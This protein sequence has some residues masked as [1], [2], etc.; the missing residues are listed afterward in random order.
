MIKRTFADVKAELARVAGATGMQVNDGRLRELASIAQERLCLAGE[1]PYQ[2]ARVKFRQYGGVVSLPCEYESLVHTAVEREAVAI[3]PAWF[4]FLEYGPGPVDPARWT[5]LGLDLGE[6]PV[7]QQPGPE[8][9]TLKVTS[10]E[11]AD[12]GSVVVTG[13]DPEGVRRV[14]SFALPQATSPVAWAKISQVTKPATAGDVV[15]S[16]TDT[17]GQETVAASYRY[18]D[19]TPSF[20]QYRFPIGDDASKVVHAVVRRRLY[21]VKTDSDEL[22]ITNLA[23]LRLGVKAVA[24]EDAGRLADS[25]AAFT[26]AAGILAAEARLY[27]AG[28]HTVPVNVSRVAALSTRSDIY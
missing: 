15:L 19:L 16:Y 2:Y 8:G 4:E 14:V 23:A 11:G 17:F 9:A 1:W 21:P 18:R 20:R 3:Q 27:R 22:F 12:T 13:Y 26:L 5:N 10:T 24:F 7:Y 6:S 28:Q 25:E